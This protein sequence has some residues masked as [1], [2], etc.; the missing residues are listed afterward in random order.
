MEK[1]SIV[2]KPDSLYPIVF[3]IK[4]ARSVKMNA[5]IDPYSIEFGRATVLPTSSLVFSIVL[6]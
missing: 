1:E 5:K 2:S 4:Y 6:L 3:A